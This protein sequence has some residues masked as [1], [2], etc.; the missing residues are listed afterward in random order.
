[1][2]SVC[3]EHF[4]RDIPVNVLYGILKN[5]VIIFG[6]PYDMRGILSDYLHPRGIQIQIQIDHSSKNVNI[7]QPSI[8]YH[9]L[10]VAV[11][12]FQ[13]HRLRVPPPRQLRRHFFPPPPLSP[14][15]DMS[16]GQSASTGKTCAICLDSILAADLQ[17][18][19]CAH[20]FHRACISRWSMEQPTC[21]ECRTPLA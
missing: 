19:R 17:I 10:Q 14:S 16:T 20:Y 3:I 15:R 21:P 1:M 13:S 6:P 5:H 8:S 18:L 2:S 9:V 4:R 7:V 12:T 11:N